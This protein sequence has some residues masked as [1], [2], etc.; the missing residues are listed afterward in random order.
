MNDSEKLQ[1]TFEMA[2]S[3]RDLRLRCLEIAVCDLRIKDV[4]ETLAVSEKLVKFV[5]N[6]KI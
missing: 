3:V 1:G 4:D 6:E 5:N 2:K